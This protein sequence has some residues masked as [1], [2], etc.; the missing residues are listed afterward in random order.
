MNAGENMKMTLFLCVITGGK[1]RR[2]W[3]FFLQSGL[4]HIFENI[5]KEIQIELWSEINNVSR[6]KGFSYIYIQFKWQMNV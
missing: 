2:F 3:N 6:V 1:N 5:G 4:Y